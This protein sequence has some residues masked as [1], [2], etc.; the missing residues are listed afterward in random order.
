MLGRR[1][2]ARARR[3]PPTRRCADEPGR[4]SSAS[5]CT[6]SSAPAPRCSAAAARPSAIRPTP[7][8]ARLP[9]PA[10]RAA[11][12]QRAR[13][14]GSRR[15]R[16]IALG[17]TVHE[18]SVFARK[19]YFY[20]D[21]PKG[22]QISQFDRPLATGG[23]GRVRLARA[24]PDRGRHH[25]APRRGGRRQADARPV[26]G[27]DRDR[28]QPGRHA[29]G[30]D[31]ERARPPLA[32]GG[33]RLPHHAAADPGLRRR[34]RLQ[35]GAGKPPGGREH[36]DPAG[37]ATRARHQD[38]G[39]EPELLRQ[40]RAGA[41]G[42]ARAADRAGRA[43]RADRPGD[44][45]LQRR[46]RPGAAD[47]GRR[48]RATTTAISRTPTCR[49]WCSRPSG[50][51]SSARRCR[52]CPRRG[53]PGSRSP[54]GCRPM[55]RACS[56]ARSRSREYFESVVSAGVEP[57]TAA[58]WVMGDVMTTFNESGGFPVEAGRLAGAGAL[59]RDGVVS[60]QAAKRVYAELAQHPSEEPRARRRAARPGPGER[61][62]RARRLGGRGAR[63]ASGRGGALQRRRDQ[64]DG[65]LRRPG[66]EAEPGQGGSERRAARATGEV[67]V[68]PRGSVTRGRHPERGRG[69]P[70]RHCVLLWRLGTPGLAP[71]GWDAR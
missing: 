26:P 11:R 56:P 64:A 15:G 31:R 42:R 28:S 33:A 2:G 29:A 18:T 39:E 66:D 23:P 47:C 8:S 53:G 69:V 52:S 45:A 50:S 60:H 58:N 34:E 27:K 3:S 24:G 41:R 57:K 9:R 5:R 44:P 13:P 17:C 46:H 22:Y 70:S 55:T 10:R 16:A 40:R 4:P 65:I 48:R 51:P 12:A 61:P 68:A 1:R 71:A 54:T 49:R 7:T 62:G 37:R 35:H 20:P 6:C 32:G 59:V 14:S 36:L 43:G 25:P 38:R 63:R 67:G 21:L 30:G 19:N